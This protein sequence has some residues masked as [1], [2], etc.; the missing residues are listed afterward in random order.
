MSTRKKRNKSKRNTRKN[1]FNTLK[2]NIIDINGYSVLLLPISNSKVIRVEGLL[3]GGCIVEN[4]NNTGISHLLEHVLMEGWEKCKKKHCTFF[5]EK[6]GTFSNAYT[7]DTYLHFWQQGLAIHKEL[8]LDY[9]VSSIVNPTFTKKMI[10]K[11]G[12]A[13]RNELNSYVNEPSWKLWDIVYKNMYNIEGLQYCQ[14]YMQQL[15]ILPKLNKEILSK[16]FREYFNQKRILFVITGKFEK[17]NII[18]L[19]KKK[20]TVRA[21]NKL[22][23]SN[24]CF[25]NQKKVLFVQNKKAKNTD[26]KIFFPVSIF[27]G[28]KDFPYLTTLSE[29]IGG[30]FSSILM[31]ELRVKHELV[32]GA[33][34]NFYT[35]FCGSSCEI[36]ISTLDK[37]IL[38]V[39]HMVFR[40]ISKYKKTKIPKNKLENV[41]NKDLVTFYESKF[42]NTDKLSS[43]FK[44]QFL[45]QL[46]K[47]KKHIYSYNEYGNII[48]NMSLK[49]VQSLFNKIFNT[50]HCIVSY[51]GKKKVNFTEKDY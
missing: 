27:R 20:L 45:F 51:I 23:C 5:W 28:D 31:T 48:K 35:N 1:K 19:L 26:I 40:I 32:Y 11:E 37:N 7:E 42:D 16:F 6:Y 47:K 17:N 3:Y 24:Q 49:K 12:N 10:D 13:V 30:D 36:E 18:K 50:D 9:I 2:P 22:I 21:P 8:I 43:F 34:C 25:T 15:K 38:K 33:K 29:I 41:K 14:D 39:L 46:H 4:K 44:F